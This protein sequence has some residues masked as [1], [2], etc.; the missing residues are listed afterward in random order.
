VVLAAAGKAKFDAIFTAEPSALLE[1]CKQVNG[2]R[3]SLLVRS[4]YSAPNDAERAQSAERR[5]L[6]LPRASWRAFVYSVAICVMATAHRRRQA[7][8]CG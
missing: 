8:R 2:A 5:A 4:G 6:L 1:R 7:A 3:S